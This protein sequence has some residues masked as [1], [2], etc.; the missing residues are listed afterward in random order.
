MQDDLRKIRS[1]RPNVTQAEA[2]A[3]FQGR[4]GT[5]LR[6]ALGSELRTVAAAYL[7]FRLYEVEVNNRGA[8]SIALFAPDAVNG[9][10]DPYQFDHVPRDAE[11]ETIETR[12]CPAA[13]MD[14]ARSL[15]LLEGKVER[16]VFQAGFFRVRGLRVRARRL[17]LDFHVPYWLG[18][19]GK[20]ARAGLQVMDAVRREFQGAKA[21]ALFR[22]WLES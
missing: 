3:A 2:V 22:D 19:F 8:G 6:R 20:G 16:A 9:S 13:Q 11:L 17:P 18:F 12:N 7:P 10:L 5:L 21:R 4:A 15:Q 1:L 14:E